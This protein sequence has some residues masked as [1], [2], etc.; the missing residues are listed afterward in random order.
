MNEPDD[1]LTRTTAI[2]T[3]MLYSLNALLSVLASGA[4]ATIVITV[5][6]VFV[7]SQEQG[8]IK[9]DVAALQVKEADF[10]AAFAGINRTLADVSADLKHIQ[11]ELDKGP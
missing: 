1:R 8:N 9:R 5:N 11:R 6:W 7:L 3:W 10:T 4:V 2:P